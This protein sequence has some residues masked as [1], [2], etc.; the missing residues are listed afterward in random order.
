MI[1]KK[2][3]EKIKK[4]QKMRFIFQ[5]FMVAIAGIIGGFSFCS[6][7]QPAQIIP[8]GL[9]GLAQIIHNLF[10][11]QLIDIPTSVI[12]LIINVV[13]FLISL[14]LFGW[15]FLVLTFVGLATYTLAMEFFSIPV[16]VAQADDVLL[17]SIIGGFCMALV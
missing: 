14:R 16:L 6:F 13:L 7:F 2:V 4:D 5:I 17:Y 10:Y 8:T 11:S 9:S 15:K 1:S 3:A 12:Y